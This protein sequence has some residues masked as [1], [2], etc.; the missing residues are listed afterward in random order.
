MYV[1]DYI[2]KTKDK[3]RVG[4]KLN[5]ENYSKKKEEGTI[6]QITNYFAVVQFKNWKECFHWHDLHIRNIEP[7]RPN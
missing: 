1:D 4:D 2:K 7:R 3:Y 5:I 6:V